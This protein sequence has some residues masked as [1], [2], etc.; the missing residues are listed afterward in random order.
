MNEFE[1]T[2]RD[3]VD[4]TR[5]NLAAAEAGGLEHEVHLHTARVRD[6][7]DIAGRHGIDTAGWADPPTSEASS[8]SSSS[9]D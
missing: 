8:V 1:A 3:E 6:L 9:S 4:R 2:L 5:R 7:L